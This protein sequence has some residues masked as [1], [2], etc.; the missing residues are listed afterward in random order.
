MQI[1]HLDRLERVDLR[2]PRNDAALPRRALE[3]AGIKF[4]NGGEPGVKLEG[5]GAEGEVSR[6]GPGGAVHGAILYSDDITTVRVSHQGVLVPY[7]DCTLKDG[8]QRA[9]VDLKGQPQLAAALP[10]VKDWPELGSMVVFCN[11]VDTPFTTF[12]CDARYQKVLNENFYGVD[13]AATAY[14][15]VAFASSSNTF[16]EIADLATYLARQIDQAGPRLTDIELLVQRTLV[17][18]EPI[19]SMHVDVK[20]YG[21]GQQQAG[22]RLGTACQCVLEALKAAAL[23][24]RA[25]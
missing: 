4:T 24:P 7:P 16:S 25:P 15:D 5:E 14:I 10:E 19:W 20:S 1:E 6:W 18:E 21:E 11:E 2:H 22:S 3:E 23:R 13:C 9:Y 8:V 17:F 12:G